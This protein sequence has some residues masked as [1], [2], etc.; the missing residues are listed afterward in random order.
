M[1]FANI[2]WMIHYQGQSASDIITGGG[3][4]RDDDKHEELLI[5]KTFMICVMG[6]CSL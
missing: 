6:M 3:S 4:Y 1:L 2:G 5:S